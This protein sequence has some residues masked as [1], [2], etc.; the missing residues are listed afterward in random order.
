VNSNPRSFSAA[1]ID[2][3]RRFCVLRV[4]RATIQA[5]ILGRHGACVYAV[6][7]S[8][9]RRGSRPHARE[10]ETGPAMTIGHDAPTDERDREARIAELKCRLA[11][12]AG[13]AFVAWEADV[14][15][16]GQ[17]EA[18]WR[19][20]MKFETA[21]YTTAFERLAKTG[22]QLPE[23]DSL[24]A[25]RLSAKLAEAIDGLARIRIFISQTDH[26][27]DRELYTQLWREILHEEIPE[28]W[29]DDGGAWH[30]DLLATGSDE[31][32]YL[33][34]KYYADEDWRREWLNRFP[35]YVL[36]PHED[37]PYD[38]DCHLPQP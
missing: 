8:C 32:A 17:R 24:D 21:S 37:P 9:R 20:V 16:A 1:E 38:R 27:S 36:P 33:Y 15:S 2:R 5:G 3:T 19:Q 11:Q 23:P 28:G 25:A 7:R 26:L 18:F 35:D 34:L 12:M 10:R 6:A 13:G 31:H 4:R 29:D 14:L 30:V 22:V